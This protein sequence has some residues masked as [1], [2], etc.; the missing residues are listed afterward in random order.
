[1]KNYLVM[2]FCFP[3]SYPIF[4]DVFPLFLFIHLKFFRIKLNCLFLM[5]KKELAWKYFICFANFSNSC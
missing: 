3:E 2:I 4:P 1:M 5:E